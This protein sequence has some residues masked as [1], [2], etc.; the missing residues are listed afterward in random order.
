SAFGLNDRL[1]RALD[2]L[3][4][5]SPTPIQKRAIPVVLGGGDL[6]AGA[7]TGT[8]KT[9]TFAIPVL[10]HLLRSPSP[11]GKRPVRVLVITPTRE[12]ALQ[13]A[14]HTGQLGKYTQ[15]ESAVLLGG[16]K[17][18]PQADSLAR[19][20]DIVVAT[21][22]RLLDHCG[23]GVLDL[24][25]VE[26]LILDEA[27]RML[28]MGFLPDIKRV[29]DLVPPD[30][31]SLL[32]SA[33]FS[34]EIKELV[35]HILTDPTTVEVP[36]A[37]EPADLVDQQGIFV[38]RRRKRALL[39][40]MI[41]QNQWERVLVFCRTKHSANRLTSELHRDGLSA[42]AIHGNRSQHARIRALQSFK[43]GR[44]RVL[45]ATDIASRGLDI[46]ALPLVINYELPFNAEDYIHR[47]GR[48]GRAGERGVAISFVDPQEMDLLEKVEALVGQS[49]ALTEIEGFR[50][51]ES[52][53]AEPR[54][55][56][57]QP[58][59][60]GPRREP[61]QRQ[62]SQTPGRSQGRQRGGAR[63]EKGPARQ[64]QSPDT[65]RQDSRRKKPFG[66]SAPAP[67]DG[68]DNRG[69][70]REKSSGGA[71]RD[72]D[73][74]NRVDPT[75][76][77]NLDD[78]NRWN[79]MDDEDTTLHEDENRWNRWEPEE[80]ISAEDDDRWNRIDGPMPMKAPAIANQRAH[81][82][83]RRP[84]R[85]AHRRSS[86]SP[87][88]QSRAPQ[89]HPDRSHQE[90]QGPARPDRGNQAR[91]DRSGPRHSDRGNSRRSDRGNQ[92]GNQHAGR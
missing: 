68:G 61:D 65:P 31:Q 26:I 24:S 60:P 1:L 84:A 34:R 8:G 53:Q 17:K 66:K 48:T 18:E 37:N 15:I 54:P 86:R 43:D 76:A 92:G 16:V 88:G 3:S 46:E 13:V 55:Q 69:N 30:R 42:Q 23:D 89:A 32:F 49:L 5:A 19:G 12:L 50:V 45:V 11:A 81:E 10:E 38:D 36:G 21:P 20:V 33:T 6:L 52:A 91:H 63:S 82:P 22:G 41:D 7:Q 79:R 90:R 80:E 71:A 39:R 83:H 59:D 57:S 51:E 74:W 56:R 73:R 35:G 62:Q 75:P 29:L 4:F 14:E 78:E 67:R 85:N 27:D 87:Q 47:I 9:A 2:D 40:A 64:Q 70:R 44:L 72:E 28:D 25:R 77:Q 58:R